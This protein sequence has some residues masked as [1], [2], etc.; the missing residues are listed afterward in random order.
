MRYIPP[1]VPAPPTSLREANLGSTRSKSDEGA[2]PS[3]LHPNLTSGG[4]YQN[5]HVRP[6]N[7]VPTHVHLA[8][9][10]SNLTLPLLF[11]QLRPVLLG[12]CSTAKPVGTKGA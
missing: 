8:V 5:C 4:G 3:A 7:I 12:C 10:D 2:N 1:A 11:Y 9:L 6:I